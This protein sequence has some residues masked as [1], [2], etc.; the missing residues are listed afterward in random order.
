MK[1]LFPLVATHIDGRT[2]LYYSLDDLRGHIKKYGKFHQHRTY[3]EMSREYDTSGKYAYV[4]VQKYNDWVVRDD[5]GR[6]VTVNDLPKVKQRYYHWRRSSAQFDRAMELGL[7][8]P[9]TGCSKAGWKMNHTAKKN[10][11]KGHRNRNRA[12]CEHDFQEFGI[13]NKYGKPKPWE[14]Y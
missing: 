2:I 12:L 9:Y 11:G 1:F 7:P 6:V 14:G 3:S 4:F 8:I 10:S 5:R 13:R